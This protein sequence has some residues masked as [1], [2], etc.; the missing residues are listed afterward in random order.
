MDALIARL[1][2]Q[3][4]AWS[5]P[6]IAAVAAAIGY[7]VLAIRRH[8]ACWAF[9]LL[10]T[11][12][13]VTLFIEARLYM[14]SVLNLFYFAMAIYGWYAWHD[15]GR[16]EQAVSTRPA[17]FHAAAIGWLAALSAVNG[18]LLARF[19]DAAFPYLDALTTW[20][21]IFATWL[22]A[23]KILENW[24]YWLAI[25]MASVFIYWSRGLELTALL[26]VFY[27]LLIPVGYLSW[28]RGCPVSV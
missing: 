11:G 21:A 12:I 28:R 8:V 4:A 26:F 10:S 23:R 19:T 20:S 18:W 9:A 13:Y 22:V 1:A 2:T 27:V 24:W 7:L 14:E 16:G 25:D 17:G 3:A 15:R 5:L 6:E